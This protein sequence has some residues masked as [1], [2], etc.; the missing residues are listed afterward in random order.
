MQSTNRDLLVIT[1]TH[2]VSQQ[3]LEQTII[4]LN[5]VLY[6]AESFA[7]LCQVHEIFDLN[8]FKI[9]STAK[10]VAWYIA[11]KANAPYVF[12]CNKN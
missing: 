5:S 8:K 2:L 4:G 3:E 9:I 6:K 1:K 12:I 7:S 10:K 11:N